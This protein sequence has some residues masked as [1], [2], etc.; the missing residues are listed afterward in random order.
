MGLEGFVLLSEAWG[1][2]PVS[3]EGWHSIHIRNADMPQGPSGR[4]PARR[5]S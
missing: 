3:L 1:A 5:P 4:S 2:V